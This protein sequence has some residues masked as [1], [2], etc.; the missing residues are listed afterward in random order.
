MAQHYLE[1]AS[2]E[3]LL[4]KTLSVGGEQITSEDAARVYPGEGE[5]YPS[6]YLIETNHAELSRGQVSLPPHPLARLA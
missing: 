4:Y 5:H 1:R 2:N 3:D 6:D